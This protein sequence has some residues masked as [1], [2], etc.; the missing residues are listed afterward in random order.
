MFLERIGDSYRLERDAWW[1]DAWEF[2]RLVEDAR[3]SEDRARMVTELRNAVALYRGEFC[4]D[5]YYSWAEPIRDRCRSL[6][7]ESSARLADLLIEAREYNEA[8]SVLDRA[9]SADP[10]CE[11]LVRRAMAIEATLG[12][13]AAALARYR[14]LERILEEELG[15]EPDPE[16]QALVRRLVPPRH[17]NESA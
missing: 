4:D 9:V 14:K 13:R 15:V 2:E 11:D 6:L 5:Q 12:R 3:R 1:V 8:L 16:T 10:V 7:V 17:E